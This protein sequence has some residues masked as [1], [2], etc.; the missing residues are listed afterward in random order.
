MEA[1]G[2]VR[3]DALA[4]NRALFARQDG[5]EHAWRV[6]IPALD[7]APLHEYQAGTLGPAEADRLVAGGCH[8]PE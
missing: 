5:V 8:N 3:A 4:G 1:Y 2:R 6:V 7:P